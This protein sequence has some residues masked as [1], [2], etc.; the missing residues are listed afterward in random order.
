MSAPVL[1]VEFDYTFEDLETAMAAHT[2]GPSTVEQH[3]LQRQQKSQSRR[4]LIGWFLFGALTIALFLLLQNREARRGGPPPSPTESITSSSGRIWL[5]DLIV[6][7]IALLLA[8]VP[9]LAYRG[10]KSGKKQ[11]RPRRGHL[12][13]FGLFVTAS[14]TLILL[15]LLESRRQSI[16]DDEPVPLTLWQLFQP[17]AV[18]IVIAVF[19]AILT[20]RGTQSQVRTY[21]ERTPV[22]H[23]RHH[24]RIFHD[25]VEVSDPLTTNR[26]KW[27]A[28]QR[29]I[30]T[31]NTLLLY[32]SD[33][34][35]HFFPRRLFADGQWTQFTLLA[36]EQIEHRPQAFPVLPVHPANPAA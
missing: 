36:R 12:V 17:H 23:R 6:P 1:E 10:R 26:L 32:V 9:T 25:E 20:L 21:W 2:P 19:V 8:L 7:F 4:G 24:L 34:Q 33:N 28:F 22:F 11:V 14:I 29:L 5:F 18:W 30:E 13:W 35:F 31:E 16:A 27:L 15:K 3:E